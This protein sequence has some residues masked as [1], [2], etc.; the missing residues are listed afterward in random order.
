MR[1]GVPFACGKA[2]PVSQAHNTGSHLHN[3]VWAWDFRMPTGTPIVS[4]SDGVVRMARGDSN[5][6]GCDPKFASKA[7][8]VV[9]D[10]GDGLETQYLHFASVI[11]T[12]GQKIRRGELLGYSGGTGWSCG[13]HLH[14]KVAQAT[15]RGW[16]NPSVPA[17][18][19]GY[20][21]PQRG[22]WINAPACTTP[23]VL[24]AGAEVPNTREDSRASSAAELVDAVERRALA[25]KSPAEVK[26][27]GATGRATSDVDALMPVDPARQGQAAGGTGV[28]K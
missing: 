13:P 8:Y 21:D 25:E 14:F 6:G 2:F 5:E 10:H 3:D 17:E 26:T 24:T 11:V 1:I 23:E 15:G 4:A 16:N 19:E 28:A 7:N 27:A 9:V 22:A 12:P 20:G 18:I